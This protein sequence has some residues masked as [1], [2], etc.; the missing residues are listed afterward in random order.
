[1]AARLTILGTFVVVLIL[2]VARLPLSAPEWLAWLRP[3]WAV[4]VCFFWA[5]TAPD[6]SSIFYAWLLG[7][8]LDVSMSE[9]FGTHSFGLAL[10]VYV[11]TRFSQRLTMFS[12]WR[13]LAVLFSLALVAELIAALARW[14]AIDIEPSPAL[15]LQPAVTV[16][17][18][19]LLAALLAP[20]A[21]RFVVE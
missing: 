17:L 14:T 18:Y 5:M 3:N 4:A 1:M 16:A 15:L 13:C 6:R 12:V 8:L 9:P 7:L 21:A 10:T 2:A 19:P 20:L 11:A